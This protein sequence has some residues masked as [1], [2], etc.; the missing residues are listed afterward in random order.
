MSRVQKIIEKIKKEH[1]IKNGNLKQSFMIG[2]MECFTNEGQ[3]VY[4]KYWS[5]QKT[6]V[7]TVYNRILVAAD[8]IALYNDAL[9]CKGHYAQTGNN[10]ISG[11]AAD[12][13]YIIIP[14]IPYQLKKALIKDF[15]DF[16]KALKDHAIRSLNCSAFAEYST[17]EVL[18]KTD[19]VFKEK[20][21]MM[22]NHEQQKQ[23]AEYTFKK[24]FNFDNYLSSMFN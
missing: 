21:R 12:K 5:G 3:I 9:Y 1:T 17:L 7:E 18:E 19:P 14:F 16:A 22:I 6:L 20:R 2:L 13:E 8:I 10:S 24:E 11:D 4:P 23:Q 15:P